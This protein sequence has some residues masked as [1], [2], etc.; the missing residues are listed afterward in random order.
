MPRNTRDFRQSYGENMNSIS[1]GLEL[2]SGR[3]G[4]IDRRTDERTDGITVANTRYNYVSSR[5]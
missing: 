3:D 4:W 2:V 1:S 5:A